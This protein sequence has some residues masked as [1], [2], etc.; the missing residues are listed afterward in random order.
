MVHLLYQFRDRAVAASLKQELVYPVALRSG[1]IPRPRGRGLIEADHEARL[2][3]GKRE[4]S[5]TARSR[6]H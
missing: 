2:Q 4:N 3:K 5:A 1:L 6:P